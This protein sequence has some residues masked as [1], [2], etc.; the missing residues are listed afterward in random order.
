MRKG[1][2]IR[3]EEKKLHIFNCLCK[4]NKKNMQE[5]IE[6]AVDNYI[7][8]NKEKAEYLQGE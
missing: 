3:I 8:E 4:M 6:L 5:I 1:M 2:L 7:S